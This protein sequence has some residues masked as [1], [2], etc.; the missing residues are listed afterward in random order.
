MDSLLLYQPEH[1]ILVSADALWEHGF[2][3]VFPE[4]F[5][6][7]GFGAQEATL[8][9]IGKLRVDVVIPGHGRMFRDCGPALERAHQRLT[10]LR[11]N[12]ERHGLLAM[13]VGLSFMLLD[14]GRLRL[15]DLES[16]YGEL[17]LIQRINRKY[18]GKDTAELTRE[19]LGSLISAGVAQEHDGW[20]LPGRQ[21]H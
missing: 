15:A 6:E 12:P 17:P 1:R 18:F 4:F 9:A 21:A 3:I 2:G 20:V 14:R 8:Q 7:P 13:K 19:V 10:Y 11:A 16:T 5:D